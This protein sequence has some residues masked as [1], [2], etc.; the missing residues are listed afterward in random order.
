MQ[1]FM[2]QMY[3]KFVSF[4]YYEADELHKIIISFVFI[5]FTM[6]HHDGVAYFFF[7]EMVLLSISF[8]F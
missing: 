8:S 6:M 1:Q 2:Q 4:A 3:Q 7:I 5:D